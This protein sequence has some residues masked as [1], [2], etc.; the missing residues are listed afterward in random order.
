VYNVEFYIGK[1]YDDLVDKQT[2]GEMTEEEMESKMD[3]ISLLPVQELIK[4]YRAL[5]KRKKLKR[6]KK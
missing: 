4:R 2:D 3:A 6:K 1:L 5:L